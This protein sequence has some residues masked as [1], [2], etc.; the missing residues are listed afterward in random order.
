M[1]GLDGIREVLRP[2]ARRGTT[3]EKRKTGKPILLR[4]IYFETLQIHD[5]SIQL[6]QNASNALQLDRYK[7]F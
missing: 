3:S 5:R 2:R 1:E 4:R 6:K 7:T